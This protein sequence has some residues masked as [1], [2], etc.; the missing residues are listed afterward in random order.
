MRSHPRRFCLDAKVEV[1][2]L[3]HRAAERGE[4][5]ATTL[6][7]LTSIVLATFS[8]KSTRVLFRASHSPELSRAR[9][10]DDET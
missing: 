1:I 5:G 6:G 4:T 10:R 9:R 7:A 8:R 2:L 3:P